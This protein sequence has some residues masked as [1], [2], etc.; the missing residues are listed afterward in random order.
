MDLF[1]H[2][3]RNVVVKRE[4]DAVVEDGKVLVSFVVLADTVV[5]Q[6]RRGRKPNYDL[7]ISTADLVAVDSPSA[8]LLAKAEK[9]LTGLQAAAEETSE[10]QNTPSEVQAEADATASFDP[11]AA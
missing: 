11:T 8:E 2:K 3:N 7:A 1:V 5:G 6:A 10:V 4:T 9:A